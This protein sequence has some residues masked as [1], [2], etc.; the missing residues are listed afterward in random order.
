MGTCKKINDNPLKFEIIVENND[1]LAW[2]RRAL[3]LP[4]DKFWLG[5]IEIDPLDVNT[6]D[7]FSEIDDEFIRRKLKK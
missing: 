6:L 3:S 7:F 4:N 2:L 5:D 1:E